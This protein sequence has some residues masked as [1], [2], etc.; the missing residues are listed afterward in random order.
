M[1]VKIP[2]TELLNNKHETIDK[3]SI[4]KALKILIEDQ[5]KGLSVINKAKKE[6]QIVITEIYKHLKKNKE[7]RL[8]Y[9]GAGT[10]GRIGVQ[11]GV[12]L[13]PTFG[14]PLK[15]IDFMLAG[16]MEALTR[17][18]EGAEDDVK[19]SKI[20]VD[21]KKINKNDVLIGLAASG[22]T[23]FTCEV[24]KHSS[25]K[26]ALTVAISNNPNGKI[27]KHADYKVILNTEEEVIAGST[28][29]KAGT[30]QKVCLNMISSMVM[31]KMGKIKNGLM[32]NLIPTNI[33]LT[34][35]KKMIE[36]YLKN[37]DY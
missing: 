10:S 29:L 31:V 18:I 21:K 8:I 28:R 15:R 20:I 16:G 26:K 24:I 13:Y 37:K 12:E 5:E 27:L 1:L 6:I 30:T 2:K 23:P 14:W 4:D 17:S 3:L 25:K 7:G 22:N 33:K 11:D 32:V 19:S 35:R 36:K 34:K 9:C